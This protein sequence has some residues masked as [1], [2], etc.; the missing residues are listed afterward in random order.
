MKLS[1]KRKKDYYLF[2]E[3]GQIIKEEKNDDSV[4]IM[5][6][7]ADSLNNMNKSTNTHKDFYDNISKYINKLPKRSTFNK[8]FIISISIIMILLAFNLVRIF[9]Y[10]QNDS[11]NQLNIGEFA[12]N[13][14]NK[15]DLFFISEVISNSNSHI[16]KYY[17]ELNIIVQ[18]NNNLSNNSDI[19]N[20]KSKVQTDL[21]DID[22]LGNYIE[23]DNFEKPISILKN[24][25]ENILNLCDELLNK[26]SSSYIT[27][28][29]S[30]AL[31]EIEL[32]N[33]LIVTLSSYF[34]KLEIEYKTINDN[35][36][37]YYKE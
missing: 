15:E 34:D 1:R 11:F 8:I 21:N 12:V 17:D 10:V 22:T 16:K 7:K 28:Y 23:Y 37:V 24:R 26:D 19:L 3:D 33:N 25:F 29:N 30:F 32:Q 36:F 31:N 4:K 5:N 2:L 20:I 27:N 18:N 9:K 35:T 14:K 13:D 6:D